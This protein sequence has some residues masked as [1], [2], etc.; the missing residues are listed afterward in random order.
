MSSLI[1]NHI[2]TPV[3]RA[4]G[5]NLVLP[6]VGVVLFL[7][8]KA[9]ALPTTAA[10]VVGSFLL[11]TLFIGV[12]AYVMTLAGI[13]FPGRPYSNVARPLQARNPL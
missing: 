8:V 10:L 3:S 2:T 11:C 9:F 5:A 6:I 7:L 13:D 1:F 4:G 12:R